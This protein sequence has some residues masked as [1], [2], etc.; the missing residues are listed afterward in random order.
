MKAKTQGNGRHLEYDAKRILEQLR[1]VFGGMT[2][3]QIAEH[4]FTDEAFPESR[5]EDALRSLEADKLIVLATEATDEGEIERWVAEPTPEEKA[6]MER[7]KRRDYA[8]GQFE[9]P[10]TNRGFLLGCAML[11]TWQPAMHGDTQCAKEL[12]ETAKQLCVEND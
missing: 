12:F 2:F 1:K 8:A 7:Q 11:A 4:L 3:R 6:E 9:K 5:V 10:L